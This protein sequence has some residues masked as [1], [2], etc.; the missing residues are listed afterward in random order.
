MP[1]QAS[2][3]PAIPRWA[4]FAP[5]TPVPV[6]LSCHLEDAS[7]ACRHVE[8][9]ADGAGDPR[10]EFARYLVETCGDSRT[11]VAYKPRS[12]PTASGVWRWRFPNLPLSSWPWSAG[13]WI[14]CKSREQ[15]YHPDFGSFSL[16]QVL[17][18]LVPGRQYQ[19][20]R[21]SEGKT[22]SNELMMMLFGGEVVQLL[23]RLWELAPGG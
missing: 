10:P 18:A 12:R 16:K 4:G 14:C 21:I 11:I 23:G 22:A 6:Q 15:V 9:L 19:G 2:P 1:Q 13:W 20:M 8:W 3:L 17:P 5:Y 7:G